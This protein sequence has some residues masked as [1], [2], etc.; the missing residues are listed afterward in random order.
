MFLILK[1][2][3]YRRLTD[4]CLGKKCSE[5]AKDEPPPKHD[6]ENSAKQKTEKSTQTGF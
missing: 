4:V 2:H 1:E 6:F 3:K 5:K